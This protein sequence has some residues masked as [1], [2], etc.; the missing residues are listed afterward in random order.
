V[1]QELRSS[2]GLFRQLA[3]VL[4]GGIFDVE[5]VA[6][7]WAD[8]EVV[9]T[10]W[11]YS[12]A[13][14]VAHGRCVAAQMGCGSWSDRKELSTRVCVCVSC[15]R[16]SMCVCMCACEYVR[17]CVVAVLVSSRLDR[18]CLGQ[19]DAWQRTSVREGIFQLG[20]L[21]QWHP[22]TLRRCPS[23]GSAA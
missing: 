7:G 15:V 19:R 5:L 1:A 12:V 3:R 17:A 18:I 13:R 10:G 11:D 2:A 6:T 16:V 22:G 8:V 23:L 9:A 4:P 20:F 14:D 21:R